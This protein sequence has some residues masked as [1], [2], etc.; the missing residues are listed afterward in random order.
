MAQNYFN[1]FRNRLLFA[2]SYVALTDEVYND[3][4]NHGKKN[5]VIIPH[6][7]EINEKVI[8]N[9][10]FNI[11]YVGRYEKDKGISTLLF[12][13][14][15]LIIKYPKIKLIFRGKGKQEPL[16]KNFVSK[17]KLVKSVIIDTPKMEITEI[18]KDIG[19]L[20]L[21]S[22]KFEGQGI[23]LIEA[24]N[25]GIPVIGS[26]VGG[27]KNVI[28]NNYNGL[29][30]ISGNFTDL[31]EK[32]TNLIENRDLYLS[33]IT[34]GKTDVKNNYNIEQTIEDYYKLFKKI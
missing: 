22:L 20:V 32:I 27:I 10:V 13:F 29:L 28:K 23:V 30:F 7:I 12:A 9:S 8:H 15:H 33:L 5:I 31:V 3:L 19:I 6:R 26:N 11:G 21:P 34:N 4:H 2:H 25:L 16:I 24:M 14:K 18:Y 17:N 1:D